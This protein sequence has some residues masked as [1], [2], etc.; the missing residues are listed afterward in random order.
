MSVDLGIRTGTVRRDEAIS[1]TET[2]AFLNDWWEQNG[3]LPPREMALHKWMEKW[4]WFKID[5]PTDTGKTHERIMC[6]HDRQ[7]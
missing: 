5:E 7:W 6:L 3:L 2:S 4:F 1:N